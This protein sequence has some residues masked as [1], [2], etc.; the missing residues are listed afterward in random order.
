MK[1]KLSAA[2]GNVI[3]EYVKLTCAL[4]LIEK[5]I[6]IKDAAK[7]VGFSRAKMYRLIEAKKVQA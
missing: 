4:I 5:G 7:R 3:V 1:Y 6:S 2:G